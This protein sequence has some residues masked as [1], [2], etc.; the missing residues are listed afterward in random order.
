MMDSEHKLNVSPYI[1]AYEFILGLFELLL[2]LGIGVG[3]RQI[4]LLYTTIKSHELLEDPDDLLISIMEK[5]FPYILE[6]K[7]YIV[8]ILVVL[9]L[10]KIAI[11][12]G[13]YFKKDWGVDLLIV[14]TVLIIP[15]DLYNLV[16]HSS[17]AQGIYLII[18]IFI[19][20]FLVDFKPRRYISKLKYRIK[21]VP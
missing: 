10:I 3:S 11:A 8:L 9:G 6:Y 12:V 5:I 7:G 19:I 16:V 4:L 2:G 17:F 20:L 18:N 15:F 13:L 1:I 21:R 14:I